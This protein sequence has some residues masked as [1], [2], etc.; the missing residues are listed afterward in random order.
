MLINKKIEKDYKIIKKYEA[1]ISLLGLEVKSIKKGRGDITSSYGVIH[2]GEIWILNFN[3]QPYQQKNT[4]LN[5]QPDRPKKILLRKKE[6]FEIAGYLH[7]K[8][9]LLVPLKVYIV[10]NLVKVELA[11]V[12][13]IKKYEKR[14]KIKKKE[15]EKQRQRALKQKFYYK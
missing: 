11:I 6:I 14:E 12:Q 1:G 9:Y 13:A 10:R 4:P 3:I 8:R 5:W 15:F 7:N 2:K